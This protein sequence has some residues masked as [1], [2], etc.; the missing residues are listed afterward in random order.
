ME[1]LSNKDGKTLQMSNLKYIASFPAL[2]T[3]PTPFPTGKIST[4]L[5]STI[6]TTYLHIGIANC[7]GVS[8]NDLHS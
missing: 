3:S 8:N 1:T 2:E 5:I 4:K 6:K 7:H